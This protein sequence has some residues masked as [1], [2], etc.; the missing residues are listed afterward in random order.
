MPMRR[1]LILSTIL[2]IGI[3]LFHTGVTASEKN[4]QKDGKNVTSP[5]LQSNNQNNERRHNIGPFP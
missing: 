3:F 2:F 5:K 1:T 4:T